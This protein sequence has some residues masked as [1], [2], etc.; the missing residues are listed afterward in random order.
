M[1]MGFTLG[2]VVA[3]LAVWLWSFI[4]KKRKQNKAEDFLERIRLSRMD[5]KLTEILY[6][7]T[8]NEMASALTNGSSVGFELL[9]P[10]GKKI[11]T[12][13]VICT[14]QRNPASLLTTD[15]DLFYRWLGS[16][17][18][19]VTEV[20]KSDTEHWYLEGSDGVFVAHIVYFPY[21]VVQKGVVIF[22][23]DGA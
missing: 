15:K 13:L 6:G 5:I 23:P 19:E 7:P 18:K 14:F 20:E 11:K 4:Y 3:L 12:R 1:K 9:K 22:H 21:A 2:V 10:D 16:R 17:I 8:P